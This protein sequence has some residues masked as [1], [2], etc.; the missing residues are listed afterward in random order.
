MF[1][2]SGEKQKRTK[3]RRVMN[4]KFDADIKNGMRAYSYLKIS[5]WPPRLHNLMKNI[6]EK[7]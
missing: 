5:N 6:A 2:R 3:I 4:K 7:V 1:I